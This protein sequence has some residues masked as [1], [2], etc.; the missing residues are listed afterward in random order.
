MILY[1]VLK[2]GGYTLGDYTIHLCTENGGDYA[3]LDR[4]SIS[5]DKSKGDVEFS[6]SKAKSL[7]LFY[8]VDATIKKDN[9]GDIDIKSRITTVTVNATGTATIIS[10]ETITH[11][12]IMEQMKLLP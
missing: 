11:L 12:I 10:S 8:Y 6:N 7:T 3:I 5:I 4:I 1:D 2:G 9:V